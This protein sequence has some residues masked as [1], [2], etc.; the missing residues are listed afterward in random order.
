MWL[1]WGNL[2]ECERGCVLF[3]SLHSGWALLIKQAAID[4]E[5]DHVTLDFSP[6]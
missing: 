4:A 6:L 5:S 2:G 3:A 1:N